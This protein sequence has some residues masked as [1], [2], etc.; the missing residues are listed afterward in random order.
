[1]YNIL[2]T[3]RKEKEERCQTRL[4]VIASGYLC[5]I[6]G[7]SGMGDLGSKG[8]S[9]SNNGQNSNG[10]DNMVAVNCKC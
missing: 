10:G 3:L 1:M 9:D 4:L 6:G 5:G 8:G 7:I 2:L